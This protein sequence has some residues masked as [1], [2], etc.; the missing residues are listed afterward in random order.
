MSDANE[1][2]PGG[3]RPLLPEPDAW[4]E[5]AAR[6]YTVFGLAALLAMGATLMK[7]GTGSFALVPL[8]FGVL[9]I[10]FGWRSAP[11][12]VLVA[13]AVT[14]LNPLPHYLTM[15]EFR[16]SPITNALLSAAV[17]AYLLAQH[18]LFSL[19]LAGVPE[20]P[21]RRAG[22]KKVKPPPA[23][24]R[25]PPAEVE[26]EAVLALVAVALATAAAFGLWTTVRQVRAPLGIHPPPWRLALVVWVVGGVLLVAGGVIGYLG[27][28]RQ[29][30]EEAALFL[31]DQLW[32]ET[33]GEQRRINRWRAWA[34][35]RRESPGFQPRR[36][37]ME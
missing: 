13:L 26:G 3:S 23:P 36:G 31:Q 14:V 2:A 34:A 20:E 33:R 5:P 32:R 9:G 30:P 7:S 15:Y 10:V 17:L 4:D 21:V 16:A 8:L 37:G 24:V 35:Q 12:F 19:R 25:P 1:K 11:L 29:S 18:R 6:L 27:L 28:R 22:R